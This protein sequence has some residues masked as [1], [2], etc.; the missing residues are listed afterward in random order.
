MI[1]RKNSM[2]ITEV[3]HKHNKMTDKVNKSVVFH[4]PGIESLKISKNKKNIKSTNKKNLKI[5][6]QIEKNFKNQQK[7]T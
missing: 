1:S 6:K 5:S 4:P 3:E 2:S 7:I